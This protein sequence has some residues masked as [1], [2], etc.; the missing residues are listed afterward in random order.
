MKKNEKKYLVCSCAFFISSVV[1]FVLDEDILFANSL[2]KER[3]IIGLCIAGLFFLL[4]GLDFDR[5]FKVSTNSIEY[6]KK[7]RLQ[8]ERHITIESYSKAETY[9]MMSRLMIVSIFVLIILGEINKI[10]V[11]IWTVIILGC[12]VGRFFYKKRL[13]REM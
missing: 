8:D 3:L 1:A 11:C 10:V 5:I 7:I 2:E 9:E 4:E 12:E 13:E 6:N